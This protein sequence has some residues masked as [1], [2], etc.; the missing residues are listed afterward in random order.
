MCVHGNDAVK[1]EKTEDGGI[2]WIVAK[3]TFYIGIKACLQF[4]N[5]EMF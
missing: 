3:A 2:M 1:P 4:A 5:Q